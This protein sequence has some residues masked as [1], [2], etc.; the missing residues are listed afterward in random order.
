MT[1]TMRV[2]FNATPLAASQLR[3]W[4]RYAVNLLSA[5]PRQGVRPILLAR[6]PLNPDHVARLPVDS[7]DVKTAPHMPYYRWE[8]AWIPEACR[9]VRADLYHC[10]LNFGIPALC[11]VPRVLTLHDAIGQLHRNAHLKRWRWP[12]RGEIASRVYHLI[13][14]ASADEIITVSEHARRDLVEKL[15]LGA[16][17][18][19]VVLEAADPIFSNAA[20][21]INL[22]KYG[23]V[24]TG[25]RNYILYL[26]GFEERKNVPFLLRGFAA[27]GTLGVDL[28]LAGGRDDQRPEFDQL[29]D[30]LGI[31][32]RI[33][34]L[35]FVPD[36]D[37]PDLYGSAL[38]FVY[39]SRYEGFGLQLVEAM[40]VGCPV[41]AARATCLPEILGDGG[42]TFSLD[43][44]SELAGW[45][46]RLARDPAFRAELS[47]RAMK[48][49]GDFSW[50]RTAAAS[51]EVYQRALS[52]RSAERQRGTANRW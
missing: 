34:W 14:R 41:L 11:S 22:L 40:S 35:G 48:R 9:A 37:L 50:D 32:D 1:D 8:Q 16:D 38:G 27:A 18:V 45:I 25:N 2:A 3:G 44:T 43:E 12:N 51:V 46:G 42:E 31:G 52:R 20:R 30:E 10:P 24:I 49:S 5:L 33:R 13:A 29:A 36:A 47:R 21:K 39:P 19:T 23:G 26:G 7:F 17:R 4:T 28:V 15:R 6:G